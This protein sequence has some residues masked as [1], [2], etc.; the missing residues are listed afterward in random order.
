MER[1]APLVSEVSQMSRA[2]DV[3]QSGDYFRTDSEFAA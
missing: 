1:L 2:R 3:S